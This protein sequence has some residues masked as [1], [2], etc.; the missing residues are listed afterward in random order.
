MHGSFSFFYFSARF[1]PFLLSWQA[2]TRPIY[3]LFLDSFPSGHNFDCAAIGKCRSA[4]FCIPLPYLLSVFQK[5]SIYECSLI[6]HLSKPDQGYFE[7][8]S[9]KTRFTSRST[10]PTKFSQWSFENR[11]I[12]FGKFLLLFELLFE[13]LNDSR[14]FKQFFD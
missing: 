11:T 9:C 3:A 1:L 12:N 2:A 4:A 6:S 5:P 14:C 7:T 8:W 13:F 10:F